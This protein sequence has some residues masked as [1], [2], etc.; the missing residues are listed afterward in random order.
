[1]SYIPEGTDESFLDNEECENQL[2]TG[3]TQAFVTAIFHRRLTEN[4]DWPQRA[5]PRGLKVPIGK[6]NTVVWADPLGQL[7]CGRDR[8][9]GKAGTRESWRVGDLS[10]H[11]GSVNVLVQCE[12]AWVTHCTALESIFRCFWQALISRVK[13]RPASASL[14]HMRSLLLPENKSF[15]KATLSPS[16]IRTRRTVIRY[17]EPMCAISTPL[18]AGKKH[19]SI[20]TFTDFSLYMTPQEASLLSRKSSH[21]K[22]TRGK[23]ARSP[24]PST[25]VFPQLPARVALP[26]EQRTGQGTSSPMRSVEARAMPRSFSKQVVKKKGVRGKMQAKFGV[27]L[28]ATP[29]Q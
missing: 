14:T 19:I 18:I 26:S 21:K 7:E 25:I 27:R 2:A 4:G 17:C 24:A 23:P 16:V 29:Y 9:L 5:L 13:V 1:M 20:P 6:M 15:S 22:I 10:K 12:Q 8:G 11:A 3:K 28:K